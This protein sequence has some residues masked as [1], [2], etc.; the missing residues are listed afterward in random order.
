MSMG[1]RFGKIIQCGI[2]L[3]KTKTNPKTDWFYLLKSIIITVIKYPNILLLEKNYFSSKKHFLS[4]Y[5]PHPIMVKRD[6]G[7][8]FVARPKYE[9]FARFL[10]SETLAK[11]EPLSLI[12]LKNKGT[13]V[14]V[15][16]NTGYYSL[17]LAKKNPDSK[18]I[19]IEPDPQTVQI[20]KEN[21]KLN[22]LKNVEIFNYAIS[23]KQGSVILFQSD[24][25]SGINSIY[26]TN[27]FTKKINV[28]SQSLDGLLGQK[29]TEIDWIKIDVE[30]AE[31]TVLKGAT[32]ILKITKNVIVE[33][34]EHILSKND[35]N[36]QQILSIL[37]ECGFEI[38]LFP[39]YWDA[40]NS[41]N[42]TLKSDYI[43][44]TK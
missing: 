22:E 11:W 44:G 1:L 20:L 16:A 24:S 5:I 40:N 35:Q 12:H 6:D 18:I 29:F 8:L 37:K 42:K 10:F 19:S 31:L 14:D 30:G 4:D 3:L 38:K 21:C 43:L 39:E 25:H 23:E 36:P 2:I 27:D 34:H 41:P 15:G 9:D 26:S 33:I 28:E 7:V 13:F 32:N 17:N